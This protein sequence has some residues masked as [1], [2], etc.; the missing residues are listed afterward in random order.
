MSAT[1][2]ALEHCI[3]LLAECKEGTASMT[4]PTGQVNLM[5]P[6]S[7]KNRVLHNLSNQLASLIAKDAEVSKATVFSERPG[8]PHRD[9]TQYSLRTVVMKAS[10]FVDL[11]AGLNALLMAA[12]DEE[13]PED[14][15]G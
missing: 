9:D 2:A 4:V 11:Q 10:T 15:I 14:K 1:L 8:F 5:K 13:R 6:R 7:I 12:L 3:R